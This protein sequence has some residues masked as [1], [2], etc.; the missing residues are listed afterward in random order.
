MLDSAQEILRL[1]ASGEASAVEIAT[2][3]VDEIQR[4]RDTLGAYTHV[5]R[6]FALASAAAVDDKRKAGQPL[7]PLAGVPVEF[8]YALD[9]ISEGSDLLAAERALGEHAL[10]RPA[11][12]LGRPALE[13]LAQRPLLE[14]A[15]VPGV[16]AHQLVVELLLAAPLGMGR[17]ELLPV[18]GGQ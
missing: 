18:P 14:A 10:D 5:D 13:L 12:H 16:P 3:A 11:D 15:R 7:G 2:R 9:V 1:Q 6:D 17:G 8:I 4:S